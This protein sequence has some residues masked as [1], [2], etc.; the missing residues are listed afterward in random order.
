MSLTSDLSDG[1]FE[2]SEDIRTRLGCEPID[3]L[4]VQLSRRAW[5][6]TNPPY[7]EEEVTLMDGP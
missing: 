3:L 7:G 2:K 1:S 6:A 5:Q 4:F